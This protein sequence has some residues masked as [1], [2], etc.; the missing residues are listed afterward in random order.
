MRQ[1]IIQPTDLEIIEA[2]TI[3]DANAAW[4]ISLNGCFYIDV[5]GKYSVYY[6]LWRFKTSLSP[7]VNPYTY[8]TNLSTDLNTACLK[9]K[10]I[11]GRIPVI[12]DRFGTYAGLFK[13]SKNELL[14]KGK[15]RGER[16][17]DVFVKDPQYILWL[18][19][20]YND[21]NEERMAKIYYYKNLY[22]E[23]ITNENKK[24]SVSQFVGNIGDT[25][26]YNAIIY[27]VIEEDNAYNGKKIWKCK[28][29]DDACNRYSAYINSPIAKGDYIKFSAKVKNHYEKVGIKYTTINYLKIIEKLEKK[30]SEIYNI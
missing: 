18:A 15:Y 20:E 25:L 13:A 27:S 11:A 3:L 29:E 6:T 16:I 12:I 24:N 22:W 28:L 7:Y 1:Q 19:R 2:E 21:G 26:V 10:N 14:I 9:A 17:G 4:D 8:I 23:T 30:D 5:S